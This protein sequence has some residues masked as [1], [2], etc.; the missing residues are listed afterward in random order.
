MQIDDVEKLYKEFHTKTTQLE[1]QQIENDE[2]AEKSE[3]ISESN[4]K[5]GN[6]IISLGNNN[7]DSDE[8]IVEALIN[9]CNPLE[10]QYNPETEISAGVFIRDI[11]DEIFENTEE[12]VIKFEIIKISFEPYKEIVDQLIK[13]YSRIT[14]KIILNS[15]QQCKINQEQKK[16]ALEFFHMEQFL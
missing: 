9:L 1:K 11:F 4:I 6:K 7:D 8:K 10:M 5:I 16:S 13:K 2:N 14:N 3:D 15:L 12:E